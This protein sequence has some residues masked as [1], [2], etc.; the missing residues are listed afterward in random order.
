MPEDGPKKTIF[1][2]PAKVAIPV[3][4]ASGLLVAFV[5]LKSR[6]ASQ[7]GVP[8]P[9]QTGGVLG[10][11][12]GGDAGYSSYDPAAEVQNRLENERQLFEF[13][14]EKRQAANAQNLADLGLQKA[15][16]DFTSYQYEQ[17]VL[18]PQRLAYQEEQLLG[19][20]REQEITNVSLERLADKAKDVPIKCGTGEHPVLMPGQGLVCQQ[21]G[22]QKFGLKRFAGTLGDTINQAIPT[23]FNAW[24]ASQTGVPAGG[25]TIPTRRSTQSQASKP[26]PITHAPYPGSVT[27]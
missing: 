18:Q 12:G 15:Q 5:L 21:L 7:A 2:M 13:D 1:G 14:V 26:V 8:Q 22:G 17:R 25:A 3:L 4:G 24:L 27:I 16:F 10:G 6:G 19:Q 20:R 23:A 9:V 11:G